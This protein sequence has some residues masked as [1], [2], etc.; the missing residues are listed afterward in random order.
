[1][2]LLLRHVV[3]IFGTRH[4]GDLTESTHKVWWCEGNFLMKATRVFE[5]AAM[6]L[7][8]GHIH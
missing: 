7:G 8:R 4:G 2:L 3:S 1:M 6:H 5:L